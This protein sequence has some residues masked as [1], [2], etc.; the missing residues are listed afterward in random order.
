MRVLRLENLT[1][2]ERRTFLTMAGVLEEALVPR[3]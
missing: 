1:L 3:S 2:P